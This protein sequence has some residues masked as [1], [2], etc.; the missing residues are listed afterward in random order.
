MRIEQSS[1]EW[2]QI[3]LNCDVKCSPSCGHSVLDIGGFAERELEQA[4]VLQLHEG[5]HPS[6]VWPEVIEPPRAPSGGPSPVPLIVGPGSAKH[7]KCGQPQWVAHIAFKCQEVVIQRQSL[8]AALDGQ[9]TA[10]ELA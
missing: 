1:P 8:I 6:G 5:G 7:C 9:W 3:E 10:C 4:P 2:F